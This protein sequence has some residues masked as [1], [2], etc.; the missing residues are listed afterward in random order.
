MSQTSANLFVPSA[1]SV[2]T[3][4]FGATPPTTPTAVPS[5]SYYE[6]GLLSDQGITEGRNINENKIYDMIGRLLRIARNQ[7]ERPFTFEALESNRVV[8]ELRYPNT[9]QSSTSGTPEVQS[10][11]VTATGGTFT[12][13]GGYGGAGTTAPITAPT[14]S[15][16]LQTAIRT[17]PGLGAVT[18]AG[19]SSPYAVTFPAGL[20]NVNQLTADNTNATGGTVTPSTT[21]PGVAPINTRNVGSGTGQ[22]LRS[23]LIYLT[24]GNKH[25]LFVINNGEATQS[26]TI[27]A[28]GNA[29]AVAQFTLQ[30]YADSNGNFFTVIDDDPAQNTTY[31]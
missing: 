1:Y 31:A 8:S 19:A 6:V 18:V 21:T 24:D 30:P 25:K 17:L 26:G 28:T 9:T 5:A 7:E 27:A 11:A 20:G 29:A 3:A 10:L 13:S 15:G 22:N 16:A 23:W 2:W 4:A 12:L 14:T